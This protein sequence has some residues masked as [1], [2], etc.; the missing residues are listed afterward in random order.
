MIPRFVDILH[1]PFS[2]SMPNF[3]RYK[4]IITYYYKFIIALT[5]INIYKTCRDTSGNIDN[6][7]L[8]FI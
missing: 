5:K 1:S 4:E 7:S 6:H 8:N 3:S 2:D